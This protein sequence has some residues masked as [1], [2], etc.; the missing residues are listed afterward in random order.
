MPLKQS[1]Q[2]FIAYSRSDQSYLEE[3]RKH[4]IPLERNGKISV[5]TDSNIEPG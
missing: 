5:W 2:V 3:L 1:I 4:L